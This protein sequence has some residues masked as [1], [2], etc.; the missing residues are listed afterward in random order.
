MMGIERKEP[1]EAIKH[2]LVVSCQDHGDY[3]PRDPAILAALAAC[4]EKG[5]ATG[6]DGPR[7]IEEVRP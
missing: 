7:D 4:A 2:G 5:G 3:P 1:S 6:V